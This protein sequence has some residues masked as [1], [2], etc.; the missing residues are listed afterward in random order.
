MGF[1]K[2]IT[3][4]VTKVLDKIIPNEIKPFLP[5]VAAAAPFM[6]P[7]LAGAG[8]GG[9][10]F[11]TALGRAALSGGLSAIA[12]GAEEGGDGIDFKTALMSA[13]IGALTA[14]GT[15]DY[16]R[17][18]KTP[19]PGPGS[20]GLAGGELGFLDK[21]KNLG[22]SGLAK[23]AD[24][25][26]IG[27]PGDLLSKAGAGKAAVTGGIEATG[28]AMRYAERAR[29]AEQAALDEFNRLA[30]EN[31]A[32]TYD[33]YYS[34]ILKYMD[35]AGFTAEEAESAAD[36][37]LSGL[38]ANGG[39]VGYNMGGT[40]NKDV[41]PP[42]MEMDLRVGGYIPIGKAEKADDVKARVGLNE[43]VMTA[44]AVRGMG[45]GDVREGARRM[46]QLMDKLEPIGRMTT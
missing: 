32:A 34:N 33:D 8:I 7:A 38:F 39:R 2:K 14:P 23:G 17:G 22:L 6:A 40:T 13:G 45:N 21:A 9:Q 25:M 18:L 27:K 44:D 12:S 37:V 35:L 20:T 46:Y 30:E 41:T 5:Y 28:Q 36:R 1:L 43:F 4:P 11:N 24:F 26:T 10:F 15:G 19:I 16:L 29:D 3:R 31:A 42:G